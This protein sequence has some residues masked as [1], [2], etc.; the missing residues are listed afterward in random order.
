MGE[1]MVSKERKELRQRYTIICDK[2]RENP[3]PTIT[4]ALECLATTLELA[5]NE[6]FYPEE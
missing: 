3:F 2:Y 4:D 6:I 5:I 1:R